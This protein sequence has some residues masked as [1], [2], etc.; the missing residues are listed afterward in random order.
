MPWNLQGIQMEFL[1]VCML[2]NVYICVC[3]SVLYSGP[4]SHRSQPHLNYLGIQMWRLGITQ[5]TEW[6]HL[7]Y[8]IFHRVLET[9][10]WM[11]R[12]LRRHRTKMGSL[13][14]PLL[15]VRRV[16]VPNLDQPN[17]LFLWAFSQA[18]KSSW[19]K[20]A[21]KQ[22]YDIQA[23]LDH[24]CCS[25]ILFLPMIGSLSYSQQQLC[26]YFILLFQSS[27]SL[28]PFMH[29]FNN[30][31]LSTYYTHFKHFCRGFCKIKNSHKLFE[32][33]L[34]KKMESISLPPDSGQTIWFALVNRMQQK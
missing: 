19:R 24:Q 10:P 12:K 8:R 26:Q 31:L 3:V 13:D 30:H 16:P 11:S 21:L 4:E 15:L 6:E 7:G 25:A 20:L 22:I 5:R 32:A 28:S 2:V 23:Q 1:T 9:S 18:T 33:P 34:I 29:A 17:H 27:N 14:L